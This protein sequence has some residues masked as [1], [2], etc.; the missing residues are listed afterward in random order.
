M[1]TIK[2]EVVRVVGGGESAWAAVETVGTAIDKA[3]KSVDSSQQ[4]VKEEDD[5]GVRMKLDGRLMESFVERKGDRDEAN[6]RGDEADQ[7]INLPYQTSS[8]V[9]NSS[10]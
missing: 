2:V 9:T 1:E 3:G 8:S 7:L 6:S 5:C 4:L 10:T